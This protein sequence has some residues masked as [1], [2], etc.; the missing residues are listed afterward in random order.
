MPLL[1]RYFNLLLISLLAIPLLLTGCDIPQVSA[2]DRLFLPLSVDFLGEYQL[3]KLNFEGA[4]VGG[5]SA[6][7]YDVRRDRVYALSDD[8]SRLAPARF[9]TLKLSLDPNLDSTGQTH[10][11]IRD[12]AVEKVTVLKQENGDPYLP[13]TIDP[14]GIALSPRQ[15]LFIT[16]EG[17]SQTDSPAFIG[18]YNLETGQLQSYLQIPDRYLPD[19]STAQTQGI[20]ENLGFESLTLNTSIPSSIKLEPFRLFTATESALL[21]DLDEDSRHSSQKSFSSL[22]DR[23]RPIDADFRILISNGTRPFRRPL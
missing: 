22:F 17:V 12:I 9:Y 10:P 19:Q 14:E 23:T 13:N 20:Q 6:I 2:E 8:H 15:S 7:A 1:R 4:P 5:L 21:Q 18:E 16:S 3:P 11:K